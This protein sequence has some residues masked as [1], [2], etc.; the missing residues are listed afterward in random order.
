MIEKAIK[1]IKDGGVVIYPTE[2]VYGIGTL[3]LSEKAV[4]KVYQIKKRSYSE[5]IS[6]AVSSYEMIEEV[7]EIEREDLI[8]KLLPG[9]VTILLRKKE[10]VP[11]ILTAGSELVGIRYPEHRTAIELIEGAG[12]I[13]S[14]SANISGKKPPASF[15]EI[16]INADMIIDGGRCKYGEPSTIVDL[17]KKK[18]L[19]KGAGY[20]KVKGII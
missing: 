17:T 14:T 4:K 20:D 5:P 19:R 16:R 8:R 13:T 9:P 6:L 3:A 1:I 15:E 7:A 12:V 10:V 18:I 11:D 2:T